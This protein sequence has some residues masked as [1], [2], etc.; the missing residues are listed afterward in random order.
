MIPE[1][2]W[3]WLRRGFVPAA[4]AV[5]VLAGAVV[6]LPA[7]V[8]RPGSASGI[9]ACVT[10]DGDAPD[11][12][13][14]F[15]FTTVAQ[16][17]ATVFSL[18]LAVARDDAEVV[19]RRALLGGVRS[20]EYFARQRQ[21]F[22]NTTEVATLV[23]VQAA[24]LPVELRGSG[25]AVVDVMPGTPAEGVLRTGD[26]I[27]AVD[28]APVPTDDALIDAI[29]TTEPLRLTLE[30]DGR[31]VQRSLRPEVREVDGER[32]PVVGVRISTHE[33]RVDLPVSVEVS[34]GDVGGP[35]AGLMLAL[36][37]YDMVADVDLAA[38]RRI[39]GT[40]TLTAGGTVGRVDNIDLKIPA[41]LRA[42]AEVFVAPAG[43]VEEAR[44][45]VPDG[46]GLEVI[47]VETFDDARTL[48]GRRRAG[49]TAVAAA[50]PAPCEFG[51]AA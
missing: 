1:R 35:S 32:R 22:L 42:G 25:A 16:R 18:A 23:A 41:A 47:G 46:S 5:L 20:D 15:M 10:I 50:E 8:E 51:P 26:V 13:G 36:A 40:G 43:Q 14:D 7:Y 38:G 33:P 49:A 24:G 21:V 12:N 28:G 31:N 44:G 45:A 30:R 11:V 48:L 9:P 37:I 17:E 6:P 29:D 4:T 34:S 27:T 3:V 19:P 39:A 2:G